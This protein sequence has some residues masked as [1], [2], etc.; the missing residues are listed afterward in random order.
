MQKTERKE[1]FEEVCKSEAPVAAAYLAQEIG[2]LFDDYFVGDF[3]TEQDGIH[4]ELRNG[5]KFLISVREE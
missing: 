5:Q 4:Y 2:V 1:L 3:K